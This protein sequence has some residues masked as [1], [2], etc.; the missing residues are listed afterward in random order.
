ML[1][2]HQPDMEVVAEAGAFGEV[3][4]LAQTHCPDVIVLDLTMPNG[5]GIDQVEQ[6]CRA[7]G[8]TRV[9]VLTM[10]ED[11]AYLRAALAAGAMGYVVKKVADSELLGAIRAVRSG[12]VFIDLDSGGSLPEAMLPPAKES[13]QMAVRSPAKPLSERE[14]LVLE[15]LAAGHTNQAIADQLDLSVKTVESYRARLLQKLGLRTRADIIRYAVATGLLT[16]ARSTE[17]N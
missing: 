2:N 5:N 9:L 16:R 6:V 3:I 10:H 11:P 13:H 14:Q 15:G 17:N 1:V 12:R 8:P 4:Q 7:C